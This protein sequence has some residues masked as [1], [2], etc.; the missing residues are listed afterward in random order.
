LLYLQL[1]KDDRVVEQTQF[2]IW[3][4]WLF[5]RIVAWD[6]LVLAFFMNK[7]LMSPWWTPEIIS[8][9]CFDLA[10]IF[11]KKR[12]LYAAN[13]C[14]ANFTAEI[15]LFFMIISVKSKQNSVNFLQDSPL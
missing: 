3:W 8:E 14:S 4:E 5:K 12:K 2:S 7:K 9:F 15:I 11:T 6:L 13:P 1:S 10:A